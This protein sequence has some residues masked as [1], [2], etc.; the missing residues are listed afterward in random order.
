MQNIRDKYKT[1]LVSGA[2]GDIGIG[3]GRILRTINFDTI[4]GCDVN[5]DSW[6]VCVFKKIYQITRAD[7]NTYLIELKSLISKLDVELLDDGFGYNPTSPRI[8]STN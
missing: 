3:I 8:N 2:S 6:G 1:I 4:Y 5:D 7:S